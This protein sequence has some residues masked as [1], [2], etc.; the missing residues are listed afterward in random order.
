MA[1][2]TRLGGTDWFQLGDKDLATHLVRTERLAQGQALSAVTR[3]FCQQWGVAHLVLPMSDDPVQTIVH[4]AEHGALGFQN[5]FVQHACQPTVRKFEFLG[6]EHALP[7]PGALE[8]IDSA[9]LVILTPSKPWVSIDPI[10]AVPGYRDALKTKVVIAVSPLVGGQALKGPAAKMYRELGIEPSASAV[11]AHYRD[12][13]TGFIFDQ[14][15]CEELEIIERW[16]II[17]LLT[18]II[19]QD[20]Q[21][22]IRFAEEVLRFGESVLIRSH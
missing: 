19:M 21:D 11:A 2:V 14:R 15:D 7:T 18:N 13:L 10:L 22:R 6:A 12:F 20:A 3:D 8:W 4:T 16:R 1:A 5:Y 9:D 17:P